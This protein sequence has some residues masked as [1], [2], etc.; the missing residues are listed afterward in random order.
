MTINIGEDLLRLLEELF[1]FLSR[2]ELQILLSFVLS[3]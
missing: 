1:G 2:S 3:I